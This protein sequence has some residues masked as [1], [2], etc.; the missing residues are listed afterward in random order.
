MDAHA[1][2][3]A[4]TPTESK[5]LE[6]QRLTALF[7]GIATLPAAALVAKGAAGAPLFVM[8]ICFVVAA[9]M[10]WIFTDDVYEASIT[11]RPG[12]PEY[13]ALERLGYRY[14]WA[15][16][17]Y[18]AG[19]ILMTLIGFAGV[20]SKL[21]TPIS[22]EA[23]FIIVAVLA[24]VV[25]ANVGWSMHVRNGLVMVVRAVHNRKT[26]PQPSNVAGTR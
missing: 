17:G 22:V 13:P 21:R 20:H 14:Q 16:F 8:A 24:L 26:A 11:I 6:G 1:Y 7:G 25:T 5:T 15:C 12:D 2:D 4:V 19:S 23:G 3:S 18:A 9:Y 10:F